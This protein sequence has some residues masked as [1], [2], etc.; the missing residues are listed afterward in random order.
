M[1]D[2]FYRDALRRID[3]FFAILGVLGTATCALLYT[4]REAVAFACGS[5][6]AYLSFLLIKRFVNSLGPTT[7]TSPRGQAFGLIFRYL[8]IG[9]AVFGMIKTTGMSP[10]PVFAGLATAVAAV[11]AEIVYELVTSPSS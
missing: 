4:S 3:R 2:L 10:W 5:L 9:G 8:I 11:L 6:L 1:N 7:E